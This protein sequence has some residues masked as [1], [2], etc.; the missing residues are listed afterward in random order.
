[1]KFNF[2]AFLTAELGTLNNVL[3]LFSQYGLKAPKS[4][5]VEKWLSRNSVPGT[6]FAVLLGLLELERGAPVSLAKYVVVRE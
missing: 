2:K 6:P 4:A 5:T 3:V 1:M